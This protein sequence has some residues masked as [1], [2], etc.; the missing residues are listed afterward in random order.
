MRRRPGVFDPWRQEPD[1]VPVALAPRPTTEEDKDSSSDSLVCL[2]LRGK[3]SGVNVW[4]PPNRTPEE[5]AEVAAQALVSAL[6]LVPDETIQRHR[7]ARHPPASG[8]TV[9]VRAGDRAFYVEVEGDGPEAG[10][11]RIAFALMEACRRDP[12]AARRIEGLSVVPFL[13]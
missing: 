8:S 9:S 3:R 4:L 6:D 10:V 5:T 7:I 11:D 1:P 12:S 13:R 2:P